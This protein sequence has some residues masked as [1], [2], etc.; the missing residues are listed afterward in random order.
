ME[1]TSQ[2]YSLDDILE[3]YIPNEDLSKV[4]RILFG[5]ETEYV[6]RSQLFQLIS[7]NDYFQ[8]FAFCRPIE[9]EDSIMCYAKQNNFEIKG[10][11]FD[12]PT[13]QTRLPRIIR[14]GLIQNRIVMPTTESV[15]NQRQALHKRI[16]DIL[17]AAMKCNANIVCLQ[18]AWS[19]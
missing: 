5:K 15:D 14:V 19:G 16:N 13:E 10:Y 4:K 3:K 6:C 12:C 8:S 18:E 7:F 1:D 11:R 17:Y 9:F 2:N